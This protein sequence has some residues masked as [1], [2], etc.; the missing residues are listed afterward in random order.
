MRHR[1]FPKIAGPGEQAGASPPGGPWVA[2][3]KIHGAQMIIAVTGGALRFGKRKAW[4]D[5]G[6]PFFGWQLLQ[7]E[8]AEAAR[9]AREHLGV[10]AIVLYGELFGGAYPHPEVAAVAGLA[11]VQTGVW[12]AP[13][14]RYAVFD[15]LVADGEDDEGELL[16]HR[17]VAEI[18]AAVG[19]MTPPILRRGPRP[20]VMAAPVRFT[21][22]VPAGLGLPPIDGNLAEGIVCKPDARAR[23]ATRVV[24]KQKIAEFDE[25]RFGESAAWDPDQRLDLAALVAHA[26]R[27]I[28]PPRIASAASK[29]GRG[30]RQA[31]LDEVALDVMIDLAAAFPAATAALTAAAEEALRRAILGAAE[32][33]M[34]AAE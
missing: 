19:L 28:N 21:T 30:D 9:A 14:L 33:A 12:Y 15:V 20:L 31:L 6:D 13:D 16:A 2:L 26:E 3:E 23:A 22:Q 24:Y 4:L 17:E 29:W 8:L 7:A 25:Q 11:P 1:T 10:P 18:A 5:P 32:R 27:M 34:G